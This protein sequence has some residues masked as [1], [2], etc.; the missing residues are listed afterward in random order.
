[1][2]QIDSAIALNPFGTDQAQIELLNRSA[3]LIS[4]GR[5]DDAGVSLRRLTGP[6]E[7][8]GR[9]QLAAATGDWTWA[10]STS[11]RPTDPAEPGFLRFMARTSGAA[12][13]AALGDSPG[14]DRLLASA[15]EETSGGGKRW[16]QRARLLL[17]YADRHE[18]TWTI[19][20]D[21]SAAEAMVAGL[22]AVLA[23]DTARANRLLARLEPLDASTQATLGSGP[24]LLR[25][26]L[27][28][29]TGRPDSAARRLAPLAAAGEHDA[30]SLDRVDSYWL[31]LAAAEAFSTAGHADSARHYLQLALQ[32]ERMPPSH[33]ALRGL[34]FGGTIGQL[35]P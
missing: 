11:R 20:A 25:A 32:P 16:Y 27:E 31:R 34:I 26:L 35:N 6:F 10:D 7:R 5:R 17:A 13:R 30:L 19:A 21:S 22:A 8:Y 4:L 12:A 3:M 2:A 15:A 28:T 23:G 24:V 33:Y 1:L 29:R 14:A 18:V 9:F